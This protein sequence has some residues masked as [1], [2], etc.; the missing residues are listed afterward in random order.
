MSRPFRFSAQGEGEG[1][2]R[3]AVALCLSMGLWGDDKAQPAVGYAWARKDP[4]I[5]FPGRADLPGRGYHFLTDHAPQPGDFLVLLAYDAKG[6]HPFPFPI[7]PKM[8]DSQLWAYA[9]LEEMAGPQPDTD[10]D[11]NLGWDVR[12]GEAVGLFNHRI[13]ILARPYWITYGK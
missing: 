5:T 7:N 10:G 12:S 13:L 3:Q 11:N 9:S 6:A 2:F 1:L 8:I 4:P